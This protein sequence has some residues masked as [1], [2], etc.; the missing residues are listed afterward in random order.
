MRN[1]ALMGGGLLG[2]LASSWELLVS[3]T[4]IAISFCELKTLE[5]WSLLGPR[6]R[7]RLAALC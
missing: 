6:E 3:E 1:L 5:D 2:G 4:E 7:G